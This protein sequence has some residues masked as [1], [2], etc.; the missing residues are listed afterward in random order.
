M[1][2]AGFW[3]W[4]KL[5]LKPRGSARLFTIGRLRTGAGTK[6]E[7]IYLDDELEIDL[8]PL[9]YTLPR[10][11]NPRFASDF[12]GQA[13]HCCRLTPSAAQPCRAREARRHKDRPR[14]NPCRCGWLGPSVRGPR[15]ISWMRV[16]LRKRCIVS[17]PSIVSRHAAVRR[18]RCPVRW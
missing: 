16:V 7:S 18:H 10:W 3:L 8:G 6:R 17:I 9:T 14:H 15:A 5:R 12:P 13:V 11:K 4:I 2:A 1:W